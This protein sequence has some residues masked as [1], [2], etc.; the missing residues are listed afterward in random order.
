MP[1]DEGGVKEEALQAMREAAAKLQD[2]R[3]MKKILLLDNHVA[4]AF[5][6]LTAD[7]RQLVNRCVRRRRMH[8]ACHP[9]ARAHTR[10]TQHAHH[11]HTLTHSPRRGRVECQSFRL[12][13]GEPATVEHISRHIAG[14]QQKYTQSGGVRPYGLATL[15]CG[16]D[17]TN[18]ASGSSGGAPAP[19]N[20]PR[21]FQ[22]DPS[23]AMSEWKAQATGRNAKVIREFLE[24]NFEELP[25][26]GCTKLAARALLE[27]V[28]ASSRNVEIAVMLPSGLV[29]LSEEEVVKLVDEVEK[30]K[31]EAAEKPA[32]K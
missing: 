2:S 13:L 14:I 25:R 8:G 23:G 30:E 22:T 28:E 19:P 18:A 24:K 4:L 21:L 7:A 10:H 27:V 26:E 15:I 12:T 3:A 29:M 20:P 6:G 5:A 1:F 17:A 11:T 16:F 31:A 9:R 32:S